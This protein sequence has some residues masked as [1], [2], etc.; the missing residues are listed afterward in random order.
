MMSRISNN[1]NKNKKEN[2]QLNHKNKKK[3]YQLSHN[4]INNLQNIFFHSKMKISNI[5]NQQLLLLR[6]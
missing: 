4:R 6:S 5:Q 1:I 2:N 3:N